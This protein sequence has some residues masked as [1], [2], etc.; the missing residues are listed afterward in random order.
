MHKAR[1]NLAKECPHVCAC[2]EKKAEELGEAED[3]LGEAESRRG[4]GGVLV[5]HKPDKKVKGEESGKYQIKVAGGGRAGGPGG[6]RLLT[7]D[8]T[9]VGGFF[10]ALDG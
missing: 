4:G 9:G 7:K 5:V 2:K 1:R 6:R 8:E 10:S 3:E